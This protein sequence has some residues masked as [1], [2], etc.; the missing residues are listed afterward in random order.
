[1]IQFTT[2]SEFLPLFS[3]FPFE[4]VRL[5]KE[6]CLR[7]FFLLRTVIKLSHVLRGKG[8]EMGDQVWNMGG[9]VLNDVTSENIVILRRQNI[10]QFQN[11]SKH[12]L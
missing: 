5:R 3:S 11:L 10:Q 12:V 8:L 4:R 6:F 9:G 7:S 2:F 1:M